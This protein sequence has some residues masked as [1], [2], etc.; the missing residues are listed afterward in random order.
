[1]GVGS[2]EDRVLEFTAS[3]TRSISGEIMSNTMMLCSKCG[4]WF[5][6]DWLHSH[7]LEGLDKLMV[8]QSMTEDGFS[9]SVQSNRR[10]VNIHMLP[11]AYRNEVLVR[12]RDQVLHKRS[13][14]I[15]FNNLLSAIDSCVS[16]IKTGYI[17]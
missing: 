15:K 10:E 14:K 16:F 6:Q 4:K 7:E 12:Y 2:P 11:R 9:V 8:D 3:N 5:Y 1:L 13:S 17:K